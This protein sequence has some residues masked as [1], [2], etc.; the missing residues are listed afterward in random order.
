MC[1]LSTKKLVTVDCC[2]FWNIFEEH[3]NRHSFAAANQHVV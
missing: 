2:I 3:V 1:D